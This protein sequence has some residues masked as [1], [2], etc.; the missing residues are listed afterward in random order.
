M[1]FGTDR[2]SDKGALSATALHFLTIK[3]AVLTRWEAETRSRVKGAAILLSPILVNTLPAFLENIA[4]AL[5]PNHP[6]NLATS[7][8]N[9]A[10]VHGGERART[11]QFG[12]D[13]IIQEYQ[14]LRESILVEASEKLNLTVSDWVIIDSSINS[15]VREAVREFSAQQDQLRRTV[16]AA[17]SHDMRTPLSVVLHGAHLLQMS[18]DT[19]LMHRTAAKISSNAERLSEMMGELLEALTLNIG[20][21]LPLNL[22]EFDISDLTREVCLEYTQGAGALVESSADSI[23]GYWC[24]SAIRRVLEN[25]LNNAIKYGD[26]SL[27]SVSAERQRS[28]LILSVHNTGNPIPKTRIESLFDNVAHAGASHSSGGWGI[29]LPFV[30]RVAEGHGGSVGID[31]S[32]ETGT[33]VFIDIPID[34][35]PFVAGTETLSPD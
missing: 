5:S 33:T 35:R 1:T 17:L 27:V 14:I 8:T 10:A 13:Q 24:R 34:C 2:N 28:K 6:R 30:K 26:G 4:E 7:N 12:P 31:S 29:G 11:T 9:A 25:L 18:S 15:A 23:Y 3:D 21:K 22:S 19:E 16:A 32:Q 20:E